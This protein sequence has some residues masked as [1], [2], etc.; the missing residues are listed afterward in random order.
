M[1]CEYIREYYGV[2]AEV[3]RRAVVNGSPGIIEKDLGHYIGVN[4]DASKPG[5]ISS[6]HPAWKVEYLALGKPRAMTKSQQRY[7]RFLEYGEC[8]D[9]F[10]DYCY[11][12]A[13][14]ERSWNF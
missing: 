10:I 5:A 11:W 7:R 14:S 4:F 13:S 6:C 3:G 8:F 1:S 9:S 12:D 2:P